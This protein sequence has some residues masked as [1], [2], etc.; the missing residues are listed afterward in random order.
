MAE[1]GAPPMYWSQ[2]PAALGRGPRSTY[3]AFGSK[4]AFRAKRTLSKLPYASG[5]YRCRHDKVPPIVAACNDVADPNVFNKPWMSLVAFRAAKKARS[6][7]GVAGR[8]QSPPLSLVGF[9]ATLPKT[10]RTIIQEPSSKVH[11]P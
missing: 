10:P 2:E 3:Q 4:S 1:H 6:A 11:G 5:E 7:I 8:T 9:M